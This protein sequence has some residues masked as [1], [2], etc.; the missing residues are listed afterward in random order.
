M[1]RKTTERSPPEPDSFYLHVKIAI[2]QCYISHHYLESTAPPKIYLRGCF[3]DEQG[4]TTLTMFTNAVVPNDMQ[5]IILKTC[6]IQATK[7]ESKMHYLLHMTNI[8]RIF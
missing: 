4:L 2:Y 7:S 8:K 6:K 5:G 3:K 1:K